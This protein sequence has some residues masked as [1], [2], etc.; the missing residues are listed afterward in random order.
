MP[1]PRSVG[2]TRHIRTPEGA[3]INLPAP[4]GSHDPPQ[5]EKTRLI[6]KLGGSV[7]ALTAAIALTGSS[8]FA[9]E[10]YNA[11]RSHQSSAAAAKAPAAATHESKPSRPIRGGLV[12]LVGSRM[13]KLPRIHHIRPSLESLS[14]AGGTRGRDEGPLSTR[15]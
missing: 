13:K 6:R 4:S 7:L 12:L 5:K 14:P 15:R 3:G 8:A 1:E 11:S 10:C 2:F 9:V